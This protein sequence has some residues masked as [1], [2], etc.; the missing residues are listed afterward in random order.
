MVFANLD[1]DFFMP[2][3]GASQ[4]LVYRP[5]RSRRFEHLTLLQIA[6]D[7]DATGGIFGG[8]SNMNKDTGKALYAQQARQLASTL[9]ICSLE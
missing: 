9:L 4:N 5:E 7:N 1:G 6:A 2:F 8:V 3:K